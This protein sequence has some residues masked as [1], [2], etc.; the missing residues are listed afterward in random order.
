MERPKV[1]VVDDELGP[2]ESLRMIL[3]RQYDVATADSGPTAL[4][5]LA[6][7]PV[8]VMLLDI[9]MPGM[10]GMEVLRRAKHLRPDIE[11]VIVTAY[12][13]LETAQEA[14]HH[15]VAGYL[16]KP[17]GKE[18]V[19]EAVAKGLQR[20]VRSKRPK[21]EIRRLVEQMRALSK[22]SSKV[23]VPL[24]ALR[25]AARS[26]GADG[27]AF[28]LWGPEADFQGE[29]FPRFLAEAVAGRASLLQKPWSHIDVEGPLRKEME[30]AGLEVLVS[31]PLQMG[32]KVCGVVLWGWRKAQG[33]SP[34]EGELLGALGGQIALGITYRRMYR[35]LEH[36]TQE[37]R[38][39]VLQLD[40]LRAISTAVL[41][42]LDL[43]TILEE[44]S[45]NLMAGLYEEARVVL[46]GGKTAR[47]ARE[48]PEGEGVQR[49]Q[50][51]WVN[52][53]A[54]GHLEVRS[55]SPLEEGERELLTLLSE[56]IAIA[57]QNARLYEEARRSRAYL[58][59]LV[60]N[61]GDAILTLAPQGTI[62]SWNRAA[63]KIFGYRAEEI[64]GRPI[65]DLIPEK[66]WLR[67]RERV[68]A[69]GGAS[70]FEVTGRRKDNSQIDL[71]ILLSPMGE[72]AGGDLSAIIRDVT[73]RNLL[74]E[75][76]VQSEKQRALGVL[77]GGIAHNFNNILAGILGYAQLLQMGLPDGEPFKK[78]REGL[79]TIERAAVE[80]AAIVRRLQDFTRGRPE[81][82][83]EAVDLNAVV[84]D[85]VA[86][87]KPKWKH[88]PSSKGLHIE[89]RTELGEISS[90][91]GSCSE[92]TEVLINLIFNAVDALPNGGEIR[93]RTWS[94]GAWVGLSVADDGV[95][96]SEEVKR[97]VFEPFFTTKGPKGLGLG[98]S[99]VQG[100]VARHGGT[101]E[102][103][104]KEGRGTAFLMR[105]P[106]L[107]E[108]HPASHPRPGWGEV[109]PIRMLVVEDDEGVQ[110]VFREISRRMG[111]HVEVVPSGKDGLKR[112]SEGSFDVL[113]VDLSIPD[114]SG[115]E[116]I[117][118]AKDA[119]PD[120]PIILCTGWEVEKSPEH[121]QAQ[122]IQAVVPKPFQ[123]GDMLRAIEEVLGRDYISKK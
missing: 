19:L 97:R 64:V 76:L 68:L 14:I 69:D 46:D 121:L 90:V 72:G 91:H 34:M 12:A 96:M 77:S 106:V 117:E 21:E 27:Y 115:W 53:Q 56:H 119:A 28:Y 101:I 49:L 15:E 24:D 4:E 84:R 5:H 123:I 85:A 60:Q 111:H 39:R 109:C 9:R 61:A 44:V 51:I 32:E 41:R 6:S 81:R 55:S 23:G 65:W 110:G 58:E 3:N 100:I 79:K 38:R 105:F 26:V 87:T 92:L 2:R 93:I 118:K 107:H 74:R 1:L 43:E 62:R 122:G 25:E 99:V 102:V 30:E 7:N 108:I 42:H 37:L 48:R 18:E 83:F 20:R 66:V 40:L 104:S 63:E 13:S 36:R 10:D 78:L 47:E 29:G 54:V 116:V 22:V 17:F 88:E 57:I 50:P 59:S 33:L 98:L 16:V 45:E 86:M 113:I 89:V 8:D 70:R 103:Q 73:E 35:E 80:G 75:Q 120:V 31:V 11:V 112:L 52:G 82:P 114:I 95:G 94:E 71:E 67:K